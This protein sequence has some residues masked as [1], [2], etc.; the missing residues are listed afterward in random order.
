[1]DRAGAFAHLARLRA[2]ASGRVARG[3][4]ANLVGLVGNLLMQLVS[5]PVLA[6]AFGVERYGVW[7]LLS[8]VPV[9]IALSDLGLTTVATNEM[10]IRIAEGREDLALRTFQSSGIAVVAIFAGLTTVVTLVVMGTAA[11]PGFW[12]PLLQPHLPALVLLTL[13]A[14][15]GM[16]S[17]VPVAVLRASGAYARGTLAWEGSTI[18][19]GIALLGV[20]VVTR[21]LVATAAAPAAIRFV[22]MLLMYADMR[23]LRPAFR[24]GRAHADIAEVRRLLAPALAALAVPVAL[25]IN[26]QGTAIVVG[27]LLG[28]AA[29]AIFMP[30]RTA[31]RLAVQGVGIVIR[32]AVPQL[33][34]AHGRQDRIAEAR[35]WSLNRRLLMFVLP[36][37]AAVFGLFG[38]EAVAVWTQGRIVPERLFVAIMAGTIVLHSIWYFGIT[39]LAASHRHVRVARLVVPVCAIGIVG[40]WLLTQHFALPG[41]AAGVLA[42]DAVLAVA[43]LRATRQER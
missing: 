35:L 28:P 7:L 5:V 19:E 11:W 31:S 8:T 43:V 3:S 42:V 23:R 30:V 36:P 14:A 24:I 20:A 32:A 18:L 15:F 33:S 27:V 39:L 22:T 40:T 17:L 16:I 12:S 34:A 21:D 38:A 2:M 26:L 13:Y 1:M 37:V 4:A 10:T 41:A 25:A 29:V 9:Y 6:A